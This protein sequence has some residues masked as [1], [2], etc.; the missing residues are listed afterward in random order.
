MLRCLSRSLTRLKVFNAFLTYVFAARGLLRQLL[1]HQEQRAND[2]C[3]VPLIRARGNGQPTKNDFSMCVSRA[4]KRCPFLRFGSRRF[5]LLLSL[6][7]LF[8]NQ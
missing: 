8:C 1:S 5:P 7:R 4:E 2:F 6:L 3:G